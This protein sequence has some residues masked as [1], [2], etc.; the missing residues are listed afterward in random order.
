MR[1]LFLV[2][3][4]ILALATPALAEGARS[5]ATPAHKQASARHHRAD[6]RDAKIRELEARIDALTKRLDAQ[7]AAGRATAQ[8]A[9]SAQAAATSA[10]SQAT[11][12]L[13]QSQAASVEVA[14]IK[15]TPLPKPA[16]P[17]WWGSTTIGGRAF[18]NVSDIHQ[19]STDRA[20]V[21]TDN[22]QNGTETE[23]KR[24]YLIVDHKFD[25]VFSANLT[26]DF[27]YNANGTSKDTLLFVKKAYLQAKLSPAFFVRV[28]EADLAWVPFVESLYG[29]RFVEN[30]LIDRTKFG[31]STDWGVHVGGTLG[32]GLVSYAAS[33]INGAGYKTLSRSSDT[34][35]LE[36]RISV[37]PTKTL[38]LGVGGYTGKLGKSAA[39]LP[40][41]ATPHRAERLN[42][43]AAY[44]DKRI[45]LGLEYF[46]ARNWNSV[47]AVQHDKSDGWSAFGSFA[48]T[49]Q[50]AAFGRF[51]QVKPSKDLNPALKETYFNIGLDYKPIP[52]LD[53]ALV[54]KHDR[55]D[56]GTISTSNGTIGGP[57]HGIYDELG[58]FGQFTF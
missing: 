19:T 13:S 35:D 3:A 5:H 40:E 43:I 57:D 21:K 48:F 58:L 32:N 10:Q 12:A 51:D 8:Q 29:Y 38:T 41:S 31:A 2:G 28:G 9:E 47:S 53:F 26:T 36:G 7:E 55:A 17:G 16:A 39:N 30:T 15:V 18:F 14:Q 23:L 27:R 34:I 52:P 1:N 44:T 6:A 11:S 22:A 20:G 49:P 42:A 54:Y 25:D 33:A 37:N 50:I 45:R 46:A 4:S 56:N 24:F